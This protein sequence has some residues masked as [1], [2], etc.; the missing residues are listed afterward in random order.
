MSWTGLLTL[1]PKLID[2]VLSGL[3][4]KNESGRALLRK[5]DFYLPLIEELESNN[6]HES[7]HLTQFNFPLLNDV[8]ANNYKYA[9]SRKL[10]EKCH[11]ITK[12]VEEY[13]KINS[14]YIAETIIIDIFSQGYEQ[15]YGNKVDGVSFITNEEGEV[16]EFDN[17]VQPIQL[18]ERREFKESVKTL[19]K[20]EG[21]ED[22]LIN[23]EI[24]DNEITYSE[25][26]N[27]YKSCL[28][29]SVNGVK[30]ALPSMKKDIKIDAASYIAITWDFFEIFNSD[31]RIKEKQALFLEIKEE[32]HVLAEM[33]KGKVFKI[34]KKHQV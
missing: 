22:I 14:I 31:F 34:V 7:I 29:A 32:I 16:F 19:L 4:N 28:E 12:K 2:I 11:S 8:V 33:L 13:H 18:I 10:M 27:I 24:D 6:K 9:P 15:V 17:L 26:S 30:I 23:L 20:K 25:L 5:K 1:I 3:K 21:Y